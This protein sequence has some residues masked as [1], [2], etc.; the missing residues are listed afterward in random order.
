V[1]WAKLATLTVLTV[2]LMLQSCVCL[3][4][5][6]SYV[7][8]VAKRCVLEQKL[9]FTANRNSYYRGE[10]IATKMNDLDLCL[11]VVKV[12]CCQSL[13]HIR[14]IIISETATD[15]VPKDHQ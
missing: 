6:V 10:S 5:V 9:Q 1:I 11:E 12:I 13:R 7:C 3:S 15:T 14:L 4:S 2:A 8:R